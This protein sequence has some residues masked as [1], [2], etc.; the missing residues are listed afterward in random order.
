M[1]E[2]V[3]LGIVWATMNVADKIRTKEGRGDLTAWPVVV[4][5]IVVPIWLG[6]LGVAVG[7]F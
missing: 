1:V 6:V 7:A 4:T 2:L 3:C 5:M